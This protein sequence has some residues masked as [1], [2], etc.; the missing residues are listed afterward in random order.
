MLVNDDHDGIGAD[1]IKDV[2]DDLE[3]DQ[4]YQESYNMGTFS[5]GLVKD[6][7]EKLYF[8]MLTLLGERVEQLEHMSPE[9]FRNYKMALMRLTPE[10]V[11]DFDEET[12]TFVEQKKQEKEETPAMT[13]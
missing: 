2:E 4:L 13:L 3:F 12:R 7:S 8:E 9:D 1:V 11:H 6:R 10:E 5:N